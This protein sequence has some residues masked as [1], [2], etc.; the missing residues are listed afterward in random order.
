MNVQEQTTYSVQHVPLPVACYLHQQNSI[1]QYHTK[2]HTHHVA[3]N[4][5]TIVSL[6]IQLI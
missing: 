6:L 4:A 2:G 5:K 1:V 3:T